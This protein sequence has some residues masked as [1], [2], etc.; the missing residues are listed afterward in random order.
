M[1]ILTF[2]VILVKKKNQILQNKLLNGDKH[3]A[4]NQTAVHRLVLTLI[5]LIT[6][7]NKPLF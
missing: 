1:H 5:H 4:T 2:Q 7:Q 3:S 6:N